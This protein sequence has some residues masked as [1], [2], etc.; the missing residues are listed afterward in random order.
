MKQLVLYFV[1]V[2]FS[3]SG[4]GKLG[5]GGLPRNITP[6]G[7]GRGHWGIFCCW[8]GQ[9]D[10]T[11]KNVEVTGTPHTRERGNWGGVLPRNITTEWEGTLGNILL[12]ERGQN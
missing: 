12:L 6:V 7:E 4:E 1:Y 11:N 10:K 3:D 2:S 9:G 8:K 5:I